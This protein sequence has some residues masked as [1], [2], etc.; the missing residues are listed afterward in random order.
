MNARLRWLVCI[1]IPVFSFILISTCCFL[2]KH[3]LKLG[4][5][6][7]ITFFLWESSCLAFTQGVS[8]VSSLHWSGSRLPG[9]FGSRIN[10]YVTSRVRIKERL[11][12]VWSFIA[13]IMKIITRTNFFSSWPSIAL[14]LYKSNKTLVRIGRFW[15]IINF[16]M[17]I[18]THRWISELFSLLCVL[19]IHLSMEK[20]IFI[21]ENVIQWMSVFRV[22]FICN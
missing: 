18:L 20:S 2:Y 6:D 19:F 5:L 4:L 16:R 14:V 13:A 10:V 8:S 7:F 17:G 11:V 12:K 3:F 1:L 9:I 15:E 22:R 21:Q